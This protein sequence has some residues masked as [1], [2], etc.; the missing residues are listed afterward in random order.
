MQYRREIDG[1][2]ALAV[3]PVIFFHAGFALFSG[4]YV[5]VDVFFVIS[6]YLITSIIVEER[7]QARFSLVRFYERR[8]RR[9]LPALF[10]VVACC[11][12]FA[13]AWMMPYQ[14]SDFSDSVAAVGLFSSNIVFWREIGYFGAAAALKPLLHTWS[15]GIEEQYYVLFP[16]FVLL[17]WRLGKRWLLLSFLV[18]G[19]LSLLLSEWMWRHYVG[20]NFFLLPTRGWELLVGSLIAVWK[21][22]RDDAHHPV[23]H[24]GGSLLGLALILYAVFAFT[25]DTPTPSVYLL[26]PTVGAA[27]IIVFATPMTWVGAV[28]GFAPFVG[29]GLVSYSAYLWHQPLF[30]F[31]RLKIGGEPGIALIAGLIAATFLLAYLSWRFVERPFRDRGR[32]TR[33]RIFT[34]ALLGSAV[35]IALGLFGRMDHGHLSRFPQNDR[36]LI[37][38][39]PQSMGRYVGDRFDKLRLVPFAPGARVKIFLVGDSFAQDFVNAYAENGYLRGASVSTF[40]IASQCGALISKEN[41]ARYVK[42]SDAPAC[43][44]GGGRFEN[45]V[46]QSRI[47]QAD[48]VLMV[49]KWSDWQ[50]HYLPDTLQG[51]KALGARRVIIVG[52]KSFGDITPLRYVGM[53]PD[54]KHR[55]RNQVDPEQKA[56]N[57][58]M[59][60]TLPSDVFVDSQKLLCGDDEN[61]CPVFTP[62]LQLVS[63]DGNHLTPWGAAW[64]GKLLFQDKRLASLNQ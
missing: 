53:P 13:W 39:N 9:I 3:L 56:T 27:L 30:A 31:A 2:R 61:S 41:F 10:L 36:N 47:R 21:F 12:P 17:M 26:V 44:R 34:L 64:A 33:A 4:G 45:P 18:L 14:L 19:A 57:L 59:R 48:V 29:I 6:G 52:R 16:L 32:V 23:L 1:L 63:F 28:L 50:A 43:I 54:A 11:L 5:G 42:P 62:D 60:R 40:H 8:A 35:M 20:A 37:S 15:L 49:S 55:I 22:D 38:F 24:H 51:L 58:E 46:V 25:P 7:R